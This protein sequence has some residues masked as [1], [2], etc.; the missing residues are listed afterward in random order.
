MISVVDVRGAHVVVTGG[1]SGIGRALALR[2]AAA[3]ARA[4]VVADI[5]DVAAKAVADEV[6]SVPGVA[7]LA[8]ECNVAD[9]ASVVSLIDAAETSFGVCDLFC[10]N[11]GVGGGNGV[12]E[13]SLADWQDTFAVNV[14]GHVAAARRLLPA[15][16]ERGSGHFL[17][18]ASAAGLLSVVGGA[19]YAVTKAA[20]VAFAE[21]LAIMYGDQGVRVS[22]LC[23]SAVDTPLLAAGLS[24]DG[25]VG[26]GM[27]IVT[28][29]LPVL[30][31]EQ[32]ADAVIDGLAAE[33]F[34]ILPHP[35]VGAMYAARARDVDGWISG[36]QHLRGSMTQDVSRG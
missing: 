30:S 29:S 12:F 25:D 10:A 9:E 3:G 35:E 13:P 28:E 32:V 24:A 33:R 2:F 17:S 15:W 19:S 22:C 16:L 27:R 23:P 6:S 4:V 18:T 1:G 5:D 34:L 21:W 31:P 20:A 8:V 11:A 7:S 14:L 36:M 26:L